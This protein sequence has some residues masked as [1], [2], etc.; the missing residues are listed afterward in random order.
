MNQ[1][2]QIE[3]SKLGKQM[4]AGSGIE[5]LMRDLGDALNEGGENLCMLGG[6][7]PAH[8]DEVNAVWRQCLQEILQEEEQLEK[9]LGNYDPPQGN[10]RFLEAL[11]RLLREQ[12][13]WEVTA[14][15]VAIT[16][17][18]QSAFFYL[19]N[20][21]AGRMEDGSLRK[22]LFPVLPEY[23]GYADLGL[24]TEEV[25]VGVKPKIERIGKHAFKYKVDFDALEIGDDVAA[26]CVSR[27]TNPSG[28]VLT[29]DE[30]DHLCQLAEAKGI[31]LIVDN[32]YGAPFPNVF[33]K[34]AEPRWNENMILTMSLSK[35]G[36]PGTRTGIVIAEKSIIAAMTSMTSIIGLANGNIGQ[37]I[38]RPL[39][40]SG[41]ILSLSKEVIRPF[42]EKKSQQA[43]AWIAE[44][45]DDA[46]PYRAHV[47]EGALFLWLWFEGL[48]VTSAEL[49]E[50]LKE[51]DVLVVPGRY[52]FFGNEDQEWRHREECIRVTYTMP[53]EKVQRGLRVI[54]E[55]VA[56]IYAKDR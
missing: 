51:R 19:F 9:M 45:F 28:N 37:A 15:N 13:G 40:E 53:A 39:I 17:G 14:Q 12:F 25:F 10:P 35:L 2:G 56:D 55:V 43:Q 18:G 30:V 8:I 27:P 23:I 20:L 36:L 7:Q 38:V 26:L 49:Y 52:F 29:D 16:S 1:R 3:F 46:L 6:G 11:A 5:E 54:A 44:S 32:A 41:E 24:A 21:L 22:I 31:P 42:Y 4:T 50:R 34:D 33:F 47:S 48:P